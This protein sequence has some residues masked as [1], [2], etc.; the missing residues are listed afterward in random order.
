MDALNTSFVRGCM[1]H[2]DT[3][4]RAVKEAR[5]FEAIFRKIWFGEEPKPLYEKWIAERE[6]RIAAWRRTGRLPA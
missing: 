2:G 4:R 6:A 5:A 1:Q 3:V